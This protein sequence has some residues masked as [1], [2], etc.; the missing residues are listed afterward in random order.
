MS[1]VQFY[2]DPACPWTWITAR[3]VVDVAEQ[4]HFDI[5]WLP[6]SLRHRNIDN[7]G[8]DRIRDE[9]DAQHPGMRVIEAA[10][11]QY[12]NDAVGRLYTAFGTLIHHDRDDNLTRLAEGIAMAN[13][14]PVLID[15]ATDESFD[16]GIIAS[17][18][19]GRA[20]VGD[21]AGIPIVVI[22]GAKSTF[23]G[24]VLSPAPTGAEA[25]ELW[26][27]FVTLSRFDG[28]YE[29]KRTRSVGP[30]FGPRP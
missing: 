28:L 12:G 20:I 6:F 14:P 8:Y 23:F 24:P 9:L 21:D 16:A 15:A 7:P 18:D 3:W 19:A 29:I 1:P 4:R 17:T 13:L 26:D 30:I 27:A 2:F 25:V 22:D 11:H 10:R 5:T